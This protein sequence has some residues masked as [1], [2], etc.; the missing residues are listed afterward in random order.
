[1]QVKSIYCRKP[2]EHSAMLSTSIKLCRSKVLHN[3]L[4][5]HSAILSNFI[6][7]QLVA[8]TFVLSILSGLLDRFYCIKTIS[9]AAYAPLVK[10]Y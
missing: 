8:K 3:A 2:R 9:I 6:K 10:E 4:R 7:L 1:M 5:E